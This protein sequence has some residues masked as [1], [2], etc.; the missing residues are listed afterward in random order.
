[1]RV[2][3]C[4]LIQYLAC[5]SLFLTSLIILW[6]YYLHNYFIRPLVISLLRFPCKPR[7]GYRQNLYFSEFIITRHGQVKEQL[8][9]PMTI[10]HLLEQSMRFLNLE[11]YIIPCY[12]ALVVNRKSIN[13]HFEN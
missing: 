7:G 13:L 5:L 4:G 12:I 6:C 8:Q 1:M 2:Y 9:L 11:Q 10:F 3:I